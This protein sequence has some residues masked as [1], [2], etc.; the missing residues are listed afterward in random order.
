MSG[1]LEVAVAALV[2]AAARL[3]DRAKSMSPLP[4]GD[5]VL[6]V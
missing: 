6:P 3:M 2:V 4:A 5:S 1:R